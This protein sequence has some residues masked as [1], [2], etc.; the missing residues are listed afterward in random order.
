MTEPLSLDCTPC[1]HLLASSSKGDL[2]LIAVGNSL[3]AGDS[4]A[5]TLLER[6]SCKTSACR[7]PVGI[8]TSVIAAIIAC[9]RAY[10]IIDAMPDAEETEEHE[11]LIPLTR[12]VLD[13]RAP[14]SPGLRASHGLSFM[15]ELRILARTDKTLPMGY[16]LGIPGNRI[17]ASL[18]VLE[19]AL[20]QG[21]EHRS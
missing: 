14:G 12:A 16:F 13:N 15:D 4:T 6:L 21:L 18:Q 3:V 19:Q 2:A 9:H 5:L 11:T 17:D 7:F 20:E 1:P 10:V 8:Y